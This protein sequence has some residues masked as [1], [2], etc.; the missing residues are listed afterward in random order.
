[1]LKI[2]PAVVL[3][4]AFFGFLADA[5]QW[6]EFFAETPATKG[7]LE[8]VEQRMLARLAPRVEASLRE[9][10]EIYSLGFAYFY[11]DGTRVVGKQIQVPAPGGIELPTEPLVGFDGERVTMTIQQA[12]CAGV[13]IT[14]TDV[15]FAGAGYPLGICVNPVAS[16]WGEIVETKLE[17]AFFILGAR[18]GTETPRSVTRFLRKGPP[19]LAP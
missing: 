16:L 11:A 1:L 6:V 8:R 18:P 9:I 5:F 10:A 12:R 4:L 19:L 15:S 13:R 7:D 14:N 2:G 3:A 17:Q